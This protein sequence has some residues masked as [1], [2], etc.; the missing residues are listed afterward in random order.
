MEEGALAKLWSEE[1]T[2]LIET[3]D[4]QPLFISDL[5]DSYGDGTLNTAYVSRSF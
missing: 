2:T 1:P 4:L 5:K 3:S